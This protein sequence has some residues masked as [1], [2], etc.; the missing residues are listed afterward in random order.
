MSTDDNTIATP[1][2]NEGALDVAGRIEEKLFGSNE[3]ETDTDEVV[4]SDAEELPE[5]NDTP[6]GDED[7]ED[8]L[9]KIADG[10]DLSLADYLGIEDDKLT[11]TDDGTVSFTATI[12]GEKTEVP[13]KELAK[14][15]QLQGHVN[16]KSMALETERKEFEEARNTATSEIQ[17]RIQTVNGMS[18]MFEEQL[19]QEFN[20]IDWD[21][22]R[23]QNPAE[24]TALRQEYADRA[25]QIQNIQANIQEEGRKAFE[26]QKAKIEQDSRQHLAAEFSKMVEANP[27]WKDKDKLNADMAKMKEFTSSTYGFSEQDMALVTD[28]RLIALIQDAQ[29]FRRGKA[30]VANKK[31]NKLPKFQKP[32][33]SQENVQQLTKARS[34][35]VKRQTLRTSGNVRDA[36]DLILDRM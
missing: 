11:V 20:G 34:I 27:D 7:G 14:S 5:G 3:P 12:N 2:V 6:D 22:L 25:N 31:V 13:L 24:W 15:Y 28:H 21:E 17:E 4:A 29:S 36:A 8:D 18:K 19:V 23:Q 9:E 16:N 30:S 1:S 26:E 32:G 33:A 10:D 35:K